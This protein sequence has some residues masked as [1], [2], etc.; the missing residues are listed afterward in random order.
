M[1][2]STTTFASE[3]FLLNDGSEQTGYYWPGASAPF[4]AGK[5]EPEVHLLREVG[6]LA[7]ARTLA[8][9]VEPDEDGFIARATMLPQLYGAGDSPAE[10][11]AMFEREVLSLRADFHGNRELS[12]DWDD[13]RELLAELF[14]DGEF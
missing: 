8:V 6:G 4:A 5:N 7:L 2:E 13:V 9:V 14:D 1:S 11:L 3:E 10:A 12:D